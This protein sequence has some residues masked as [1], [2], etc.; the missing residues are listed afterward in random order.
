MPR[1]I[2]VGM[3]GEIY[4]RRFRNHDTVCAG[5]GVI[6]KKLVSYVRNNC[7]RIALE[8]IRIHMGHNDFR[9]RSECAPIELI[10]TDSAAVQL[11]ST[12]EIL[13]HFV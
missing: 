11:M 13:V 1:Q 6:R 9:T 10:E 7:A 4:R 5:K 8:F 12:L 2:E 3:V